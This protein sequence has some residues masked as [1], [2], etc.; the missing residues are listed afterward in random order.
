[1]SEWHLHVPTMNIGYGMTGTEQLGDTA[2]PKI[3]SVELKLVVERASAYYISLAAIVGSTVFL[4]FTAYAINLTTSLA[5][6]AD[7]LN[8]VMVFM[9]L[10]L[11]A[12]KYTVQQQ[13]PSVPYDTLWDNYIN[14]CQFA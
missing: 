5:A 12:I 9:F 6:T 2:G 10:A 13:L 14:S 4:G 8:N 11:M 7:R 1:M 3:P